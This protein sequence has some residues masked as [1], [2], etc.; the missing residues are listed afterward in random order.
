MTR[1]HGVQRARRFLAEQREGCCLP[2]SLAGN[3]CAARGCLRAAWPPGRDMCLP[4]ALPGISSS[5]PHPLSTKTAGLSA[6]HPGTADAA[7]CLPP[8]LV[9]V[10]FLSVEICTGQHLLSSVVLKPTEA[11]LPLFFGCR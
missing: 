10:L 9:L 11:H 6:F 3:W 2:P 8:L 5:E 1:G 7:F 4:Q